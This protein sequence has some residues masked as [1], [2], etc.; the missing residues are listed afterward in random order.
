[1]PKLLKEFPVTLSFRTT[2]SE[3][4]KVAEF[5]A[6]TGRGQGEVL[7][8]LLRQAVLAGAPDIQLIG[9]LAPACPVQADETHVN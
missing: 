8:L 9:P 3:A 1:M 4:K 5:A 2:K 6:Q 7:R